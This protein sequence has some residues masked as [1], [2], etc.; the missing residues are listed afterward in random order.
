MNVYLLQ[1]F[2]SLRGNLTRTLLTMLGIVIGVATVTVVFS[3]GAGFKSFIN[4]QINAFGSNT[5][6]I[7]VVAPATTKE[8]NSKLRDGGT[9]NVNNAVP[10][11]TFKER[12]IESIA[13]IPNVVGA[14]G[15]IIS[16]SSVAYGSTQ[17][18][19][20]I[21]GADAARFQIDK[22]EL[23]EGRGFTE[24]ENR[25]LSQVAVLGSDIAHDLFG[26]S[27]PLN[28]TIRLGNYNFNVIGVYA[29]RGSFGFQND[30]KQVFV[31]ART[32]QKKILGIDYF[33]Y[34]IAS[35]KDSSKAKVT[36]ADIQDVL[37][38]NH[39]I[40]DPSRDDFTV[41]SQSEGLATFDTIL[42]AITFLLIAIAS[43]SLLVGG[44]GVMNVM[45]VVVTERVG[46]IGLKKAVGATF[47][48][49]LAEFLLEA[50]LI[51]VI[52]GL[53]G[54]AAGAGMSFLVALAARH[55]G[56]AWS[57]IVP[58]SSVVVGLSVSLF[59]G[60]TFG[61]LPARTAARKDPIEAMRFE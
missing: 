37:R 14:Y 60:I 21:F 38:Q 53:L 56:L 20:V 45:Y 23:S 33:F 13:R 4:A 55:A 40:T 49:I 46:E 25:S 51:S 11:T 44:I 18:T 57:F 1:A 43:I 34:G 54:I 7:Q 8:R 41:Q 16:Q 29:P 17:K 48:A 9:S 24:E 59:I 15:A 52:G 50:V 42:K 6:I 19:T 30:D 26:D 10:V 5:V 12:D 22:G 31:P 3:A 32:L 61:V 58:W 35:L 28:H 27:D 39:S 47:N 36:T 2:A